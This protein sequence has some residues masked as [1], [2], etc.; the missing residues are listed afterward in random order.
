MIVQIPT[1]LGD[2]QMKSDMAGRLRVNVLYYKRILIGLVQ[3]R[4]PCT[5]PETWCVK[6]ISQLFPGSF[7]ERL[8]RNTDFKILDRKN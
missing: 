1:K 7:S 8:N 3:N 6:A 5:Y 4:L 2:N